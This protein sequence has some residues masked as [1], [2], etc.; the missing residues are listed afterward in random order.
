MG[1]FRAQQW[2]NGVNPRN[3]SGFINDKANYLVG[4]PVIR[5]LR[6]KSDFCPVQTLRSKCAQ[7]YSLFNEEKDS[8]SPGW[9]NESIE[10]YSSSIRQAFEYKSSDE[11][12]TYAYVGDHG[13]YSGGHVYEF[14]DRLIN[15]RSN[16]SELHRFGSID[17]QTRAITIQLSLYNRGFHPQSR[18]E[19]FYFDGKF[20]IRV[21]KRKS[22]AFL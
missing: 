8:F 19:P 17:N 3:I 1:N 11:V 14:R 15:L 16:L 9:M 6:I 7:D 12:D 22:S 13:M 2:Y 18:F 21:V 20:G 5:R 10:E 4:W